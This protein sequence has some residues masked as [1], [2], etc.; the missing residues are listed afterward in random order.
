MKGIF[1]AVGVGPGDPELMTIKAVKTIEKCSVIAVP[2]S[3]ASSNAALAIAGEHAKGKIILECDM[4][5]TR[6]QKVLDSCHDKSAAEIAG[7]LD[8]GMDVAFLTIGDPSVYST[9]MYIHRRLGNAGY[10][11]RMIPGVTSF[12]GAAASL[13]VSL[14][15][16]NEEL[17]V[18]PASYPGA[19]DDLGSGTLVLMKSGKSIMKVKDQLAGRK[20]MMVECATMENEKIYRDLDELK[21][22]SGYFSLIIVPDKGR[23][24][25]N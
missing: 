7:Y 24:G 22:P 14:C 6:D 8:K 20:A 2:A 15:E 21:E 13:N 16:K 18:I 19:M 23:N 12:C 25:G 17:H 9:V 5:M 4:P 10:E 1:Y 3:G 11:T